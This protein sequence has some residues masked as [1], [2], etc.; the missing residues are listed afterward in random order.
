MN[1]QL[2]THELRKVLDYLWDGNPHVL[3]ILLGINYQFDKIAH[4][5]FYYLYQNQVKGMAI[6]EF[7]DENGGTLGGLAFIK[8]KLN[9]NFNGK[10]WIKIDDISHRK[11][12]YH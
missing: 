9:G 12:L 4:S 3:Q 6:K 11:S 1:R 8:N 2:N 7:F 5:V 10:E